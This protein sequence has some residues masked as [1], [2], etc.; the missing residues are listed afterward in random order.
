MAQLLC[1]AGGNATD[2]ED[3]PPAQNTETTA[4]D[5]VAAIA[6]GNMRAWLEPCGLWKSRP[7]EECFVP[8]PAVSVAL[9]TALLHDRLRLKCRSALVAIWA[10]YTPQ[11]VL[12][13]A[14]QV[15]PMGMRGAEPADP[16]TI[17]LAM[18]RLSAYFEEHHMA[19][20]ACGGG[21]LARV[22]WFGEDFAPVVLNERH[23]AVLILLEREELV[24]CTNGTYRAVAP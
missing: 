11:L 6:G 12:V 22:A 9:A 19:L 4:F 1:T 14:R 17:L 8:L 5:V 23:M 20:R 24:T 18:L 7:G 16:A 15:V 3:T 21:R 2:T 13:N 10:P